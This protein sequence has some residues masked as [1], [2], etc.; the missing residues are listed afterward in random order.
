[1]RKYYLVLAALNEL[2]LL[3]DPT[4]IPITKAEIC[5]RADVSKTFIYKYKEELLDPINRAIIQQNIKI[6]IALKSHKLSFSSDSKDRLME[7]LKRRIQSLEDENKQLRHEKELL[8]G[9]LANR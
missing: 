5:R 7:S 4:K 1:M 6:R 2:V 9:K 8:L 3:D